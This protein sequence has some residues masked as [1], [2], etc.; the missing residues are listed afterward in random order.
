[1]HYQEVNIQTKF[2]AS[3]NLHAHTFAGTILINIYELCPPHLNQD[4]ISSSQR[5]FADIIVGCAHKLITCKSITYTNN[6]KRMT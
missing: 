2:S 4:K 1:M 5:N 6:R 3:T